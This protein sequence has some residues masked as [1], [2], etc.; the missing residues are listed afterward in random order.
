MGEVFRTLL[1]AGIC[2]LLFSACDRA[3]DPEVWEDPLDSSDDVVDQVD[4][5]GDGIVDNDGYAQI[6]A[7]R[8]R[9]CALDCDGQISCWGDNSYGQLSAP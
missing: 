2:P 9:P 8:Q 5:D 7:G 3:I 6:D 1:W 4:H